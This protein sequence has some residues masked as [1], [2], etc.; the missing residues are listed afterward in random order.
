VIGTPDLV[1]ESN[2]VDIPAKGDVPYQYAVL[3]HV[4]SEDTWIQAAQIVP[5]NPRVLHHGN[6]AYADLNLK[7]SEE[8]FITG[9]V[10]GGEAMTL[11]PGI[12]YRIPKG[13]ALALQLHFVPTGKPEKCKVAVGLRYPREVVQKR[14]RNIQL[15]TSKF[16]I[17]PG[18]PAHKVAASRTLDQDVLG[19]G[20]FAHMHLRGK[21]M[22]F[23]AHLPD[24][25][26][27]TLLVIPNYNFAWQVPYRWEPGKVRF[28]KGT[29]LECVAHFDNSAFNPY[30]PNPL[31]SVRH[32]PQTHHEMMFGFF[33]YTNA[34]ERL[35]I[36][37]DAKT[38]SARKRK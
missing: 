24:K 27:D 9:Y 2:V 20:L 22:T 4:F 26:T 5:D 19:V 13:S 37:V 28:P 8:N 3:L 16:S 17:P 21:D 32:G 1:L 35:G 33:F 10:P 31:A 15:T 38:G 14:L 11:D 6:M 7:F 36:E 23:T 34:E 18:A 30:N 12:G 25:K 29:R